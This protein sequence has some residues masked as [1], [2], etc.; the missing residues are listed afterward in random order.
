MAFHFD[1]LRRLAK[2]GGGVVL[3]D[4]REGGLAST[5]LSIGSLWL[6][7]TQNLV[8]LV[9]GTS[10]TVSEGPARM[11]AEAGFVLTGIF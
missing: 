3:P 5:L 9:Y 4:Y 8:D 10:R 2:S 1:T 6:T 7:E 11:T